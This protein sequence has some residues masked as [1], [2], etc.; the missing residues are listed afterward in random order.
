[1]VYIGK[2]G[3]KNMKY[4]L[5]LGSTASCNNSMV[6]ATKRLGQSDLKASTK[7][8]LQEFG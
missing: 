3:T 8:F 6:E 4:H 1:M 5:E 7:N 2:E